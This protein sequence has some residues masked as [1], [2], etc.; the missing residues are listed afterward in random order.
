MN[1]RQGIKKYTNYKHENRPPNY[2]T[3][4]GTETINIHNVT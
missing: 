1:S 2:T 4:L 3:P